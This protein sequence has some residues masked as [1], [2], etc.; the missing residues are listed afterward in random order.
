MRA[1]IAAVHI[2]RCELPVVEGAFRLARTQ[3]TGL[4]STL[5][6]IV[7]EDGVSGFGETCPLGPAYQPE[8]AR[9]A[10]AALA[11]LVPHL[12][13]L[14]PLRIDRVR[15][16]MDHALAGHRY[17]KA[18][19]DIA[20][21]DLMGKVYGARVCDL[22]GGAARE[23]VPAYASVGVLPPDEVGAAVQARR[24]EGYRRVQ[25]KVGGRPLDVDI[26][27]VRAAHAVAGPDLQLV[28]DA[29]RGWTTRDA[30]LAS[31]A[32]RDLP[33]VLE[34]P[35]DT[36]DELAVVR[37]RLAH[38]VVVDEAAEDLPT[39]LAITAGGLADVLGLKITRVGGLSAM[40][41]IR[42]V[43]AARN[44]PITSDDAWGGDVIA[45]A[46]VH[47]GATVEPRLLAGVW[48][49]QP[50]I[51]GHYDRV[52]PIAARD[53]MLDVPTGAGLGVNPDREVLG[54]PVLSV[55]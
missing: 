38:P 45:A 5:V 6:E 55:G 50:H 7:T 16:V 13:G 30:V 9:G 22:L 28:I 33:L 3:V 27:A 51:D 42:D 15:A 47:L 10:R 26:A 39:V 11:E 36:L 25:V 43:C 19:V 21:W 8:H 20:L 24:A 34:Q 40:R 54:P 52:H 37:D 53:G 12:P 44:L 14:D 41:T 29:N 2:Y 49:A 32:C 17:A 35:C 1:R 31:R 4:D 18:A 46:C 23:Q 48:I